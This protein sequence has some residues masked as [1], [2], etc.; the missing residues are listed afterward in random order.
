[1]SGPGGAAA[2][3][4]DKGLDKMKPRY[5]A[6]E[7]SVKPGIWGIWDNELGRVDLGHHN[8]TNPQ[9]ESWA[10]ATATRLNEQEL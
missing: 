2:G 6:V 9:T 1:M 5:V 8:S 10:R 4:V 7:S 3:D